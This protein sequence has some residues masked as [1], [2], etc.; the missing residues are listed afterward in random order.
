MLETLLVK[1]LFNTFLFLYA[2]IPGHDFG[3]VVILFTLLVRVLLWPLFSKSIRSQLVMSK[4]QPEIEAVQKKYKD[5]KQTQ[6]AELMKLY[7]QNKFNPFSGVIS[8]FIQLPI[9]LAVYKVFQLFYVSFGHL[10]YPW[11]PVSPNMNHTFL[12]MFDLLQPFF[13]ATVCAS[14]LQFVQVFFSLKSIPQTKTQDATVRASRLTAYL[15]PVLTFV[16]FR[17]FPSVLSLYW[18]VSSIVSVAQQWYIQKQLK[19]NA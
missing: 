7:K 2:H 3:I 12:G 18:S 19:H 10:V 11:I 16:I 6:V 9:L 1:P 8:L 5:D 13:L 15:S 4:L 17:S 14:L